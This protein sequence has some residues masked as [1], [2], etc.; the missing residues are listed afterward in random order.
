[1]QACLEENIKAF[2]SHLGEWLSWKYQN[3]E[4]CFIFNPQVTISTPCFNRIED[5]IDVLV[6]GKNHKIVFKELVEEHST[7]N[8][9]YSISHK[10]EYD[11]GDQNGHSLFVKKGEDDTNAHP[12]PSNKMVLMTQ[13]SQKSQNPCT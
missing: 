3:L 8:Y 9:W 11:N 10:G 2:S 12:S 5:S 4:E 6:Q 7:S 13:Q 1:M